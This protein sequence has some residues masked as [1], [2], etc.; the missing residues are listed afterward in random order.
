M[1]LTDKTGPNSATIFSTSVS[2]THCEYKV[3]KKKNQF[4]RVSIFGGGK[5]LTHVKPDTIT[6]LPSARFRFGFDS[7][8]FVATT[9]SSSTAAAIVTAAACVR[10]FC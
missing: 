9:F 8:S 6:R 10:E 2:F 7:S 1:N 5:M 3:L 4:R